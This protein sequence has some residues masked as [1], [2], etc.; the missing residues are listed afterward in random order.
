[1]TSLCTIQSVTESINILYTK[2]CEFVHQILLTCV[3]TNNS[4]SYIFI[5][6]EATH[7]AGGRTL[8]LHDEKGRWGTFIPVIIIY[9]IYG[10]WFRGGGALGIFL[11]ETGSTAG[12]MER[13]RGITATSSSV[14]FLIVVGLCSFTFTL[15]DTSRTWWLK[16]QPSSQDHEWG[17]RATRLSS[18][19]SWA[20]KPF[21]H[22]IHKDI[23][24]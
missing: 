13:E 24:Q 6:T 9:H 4:C 5:Q 8:T 2:I 7:L 18:H 10:L 22:L 19:N 11:E 17:L 23:I 12:K 20:V 21:I 15:A 1:M 14:V 3:G 16:I